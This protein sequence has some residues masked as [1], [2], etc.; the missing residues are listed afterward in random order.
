MCYSIVYYNV[1]VLL[2]DIYRTEVK[3]I[4]K[5][6]LIE[7]TIAVCGCNMYFDYG[8]KRKP[9]WSPLCDTLSLSKHTQRTQRH[10]P[11]LRQH[12]NFNQVNVNIS[13][14][15][16]SLLGVLKGTNFISVKWKEFFPYRQSNRAGLQSKIN[17]LTG[18][19]FNGPR[20]N[21][22][23]HLLSLEMERAGAN[24]PRKLLILT[25][26]ACRKWSS[27][28]KVLHQWR[29]NW[30]HVLRCGWIWGH[31]SFTKRKMYT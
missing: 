12:T 1:N 3:G 26:L 23:C 16:L 22:F 21:L 28:Q 11:V 10:L 15:A 6:T 2:P 9:V 25:L 8:I 30:F 29:N 31:E 5:W 20:L 13:I 4:S 7:G 27:A 24:H 18:L 17:L 19:D 14:T